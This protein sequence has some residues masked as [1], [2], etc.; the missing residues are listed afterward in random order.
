MIKQLGNLFVLETENSSYIFRVLDS[1]HLEHLYYGRKVTIQVEEDAEY[2]YPIRAFLP[3][4]HAAYSE[5]YNTLSLESLCQE[6]SSLGKGD[7]SVPL[8]MWSA[9]TEAAHAIS[10][11]AAPGSAAEALTKMPTDCR[12]HGRAIWARRLKA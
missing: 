11:S 6:V 1:G 9:P 10:D 4:N 5:E 7:Y 2:L 3:G 12:T 8:L